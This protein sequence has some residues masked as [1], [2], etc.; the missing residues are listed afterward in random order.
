MELQQD[1]VILDLPRA[2]A[3]LDSIGGQHG[4]FSLTGNMPAGGGAGAS[5]AALVALAGAAGAA[6]AELA[7]ACLAAEGASDPLMLPRPDA[8]LWAPR[9]GRV[10][11]PLPPLPPAEIIGGFWGAP[12]ATAPKDLRFPDVS[13]LIPALQTPLN[14]PDLACIA[15]QSAHRCTAMRGPDGDPTADLARELGALG[16]LRAHTGSARGLIFAPGGVPASAEPAL[17]AAGY[18]HVLRFQTGGA[19]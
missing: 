10:L 14:L 19:R 8:A 13:D 4:V 18:N 7:A 9:E 12:L 16:Y 5:T 3:F 6:D 11:T 2:S 15:T 1:P 17:Q